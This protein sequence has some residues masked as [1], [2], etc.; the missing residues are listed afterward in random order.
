MVIGGVQLE[1]TWVQW[2]TGLLFGGTM[3]SWRKPPENQK[4]HHA[5]AQAEDC[6]GSSSAEKG[7]EFLADKLKM[8]Q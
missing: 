1:D 4:Q 2:T 3:M 8:C 6:L 7:L 5:A